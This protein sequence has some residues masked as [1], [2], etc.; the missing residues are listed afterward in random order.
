MKKSVYKLCY[1]IYTV[2]VA[3]TVDLYYYAIH[4]DQAFIKG[5][6]EIR[7][8]YTDGSQLLSLDII[9]IKH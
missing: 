6:A 1:R 4:S 2:P 5:N 3:T 7:N 8:K 9:E